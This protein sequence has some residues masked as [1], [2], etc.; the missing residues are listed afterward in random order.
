[1]STDHITRPEHKRVRCGTYT[2]PY[3]GEQAWGDHRV[4]TPGHS[5]A[6]VDCTV[7]HHPTVAPG[8]SEPWPDYHDRPGAQP[9]AA[10]LWGWD[11]AGMLSDR[12][13][14]TTAWVAAHV[15]LDALRDAG[16]TITPLTA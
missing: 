4:T 10:A 7:D 13:G 2:D 14:D 15:A 8:W 9:I 1:M 6:D 3:T 5:C 11:A 12:M 16:Y